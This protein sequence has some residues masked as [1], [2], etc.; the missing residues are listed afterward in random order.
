MQQ[1]TGSPLH[2]PLLGEVSDILTS[3][4]EWTSGLRALLLL[5]LS[6]DPLSTARPDTCTPWFPQTLL[7]V[8]FS[9]IFS[10]CS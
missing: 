7:Q 2:L 4:G 5:S 6:L 8:S 1:E 3:Q 10:V 9:P